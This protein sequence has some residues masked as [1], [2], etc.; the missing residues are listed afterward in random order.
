[1]NNLS[2]INDVFIVLTL[3][4]QNIKQML[5]RWNVVGLVAL[6]CF[7][8]FKGEPACCRMRNDPPLALVPPRKWAYCWWC[9]VFSSSS[10]YVIVIP[11]CNFSDKP[12]LKPWSVLTLYER[13]CLVPTPMQWKWAGEV[14]F[15][16]RWTVKKNEVCYNESIFLFLTTYNI[17]MSIVFVSI[18]RIHEE[19]K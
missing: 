9:L 15:P 10:K 6:N 12:S 16:L 13:Y 7:L 19:R 18:V 4:L 17:A 14:S 2:L 11:H 3:L 1:M 5:E 8:I